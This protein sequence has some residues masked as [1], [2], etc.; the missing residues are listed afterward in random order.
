MK[1]ETLYTAASPVAQPARF[2]CD[3]QADLRAAISIGW[4]LFRQILVSRYRQSF[5]GYCWIIIPPL[6]VTLTAV[7][8]QQANV[9]HYAD[10]SI[11]YPVFVLC[12][13][14]TWQLF[15]DSLLGML[16][17]VQSKKSL[18]TRI[19]FPREALIIVQLIDSHLSLCALGAITVAVCYYFDI[20]LT[21]SLLLALPFLSTSI[22]LGTLLGAILSPLAF[23]I[24]DLKRGIQ[25]L[26][27]FWFLITPIAYQMTTDSSLGKLTQ[28]NPLSPLVN[29]SRN[30]I[31]DP[32]AAIS[33]AA[34]IVVAATILLTILAWLCFRISAPIALERAGTVS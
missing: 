1:Q 12:G 31:I 19:S 3:T 24:E 28:Y 16:N 33:S 18:L 14:I 4:Q 10:N 20:A 32:S 7:L 9:I 25:I 22:V 21:A 27:S 26:L 17:I 34:L 8:L 2:I 11:A 23:L 6:V 15:S 13:S 5:L 29:T 30:A